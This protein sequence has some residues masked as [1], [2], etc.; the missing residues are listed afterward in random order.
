MPGK[1]VSYAIAL[2]E[3]RK[4]LEFSRLNSKLFGLHSPRIG[5]T[6]DAFSRNVPAYVIDQQG[7]WRSQ[8]FV[9]SVLLMLNGALFSA[10]TVPTNMLFVCIQK[11]IIIMFF[12]FCLVS[13]IQLNASYL[14][15]FV[16]QMIK[17][18]SGMLF[19]H[20]YI[21]CIV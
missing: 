5:A 3:F 21:Y 10:Q 17:L 4:M 9:I 1:P 12:L 20:C 16:L 15:F 11:C 8:S 14:I 2:A 19:T 13:R 18:S 6:S 7:R